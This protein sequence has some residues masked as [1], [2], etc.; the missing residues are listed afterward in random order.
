MGL[1]D[2]L[3]ETEGWDKFPLY[4]VEESKGKIYLSGSEM[5]K[6]DPESII[7]YDAILVKLNHFYKN[8]N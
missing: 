6:K 8:K 2:L 1:K 7:D 3:I 5:I 4:G